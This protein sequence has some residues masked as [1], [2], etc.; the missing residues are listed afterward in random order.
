MNTQKAPASTAASPPPPPKPTAAPRVGKPQAPFTPPTRG[1]AADEPTE[2]PMD[3]FSLLAKWSAPTTAAT[4]ARALQPPSDAAADA[5]GRG[6]TLPADTDEPR[7][8]PRAHDDPLDPMTRQSA[9]LGPPL[10][11]TPMTPTATP[12]AAVAARAMTSLEELLPQLVRK[13]AWTGD[14]KRGTVRMELGA[15]A[16]AGSTLLLESEGGRVRVHLDTPPGTDGQAWKQKIGARLAEKNID[17]ES[18][19]VL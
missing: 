7:A 4:V 10:A 13:I 2:A 9:Q 11:T 14:G 3:T 12:D 18:I 6:G 5:K 16:L 15:G 19:D 8:R 17:V 1:P